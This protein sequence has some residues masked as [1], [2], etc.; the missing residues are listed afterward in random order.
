LLVVFGQRKPFV[1]FEHECATS[2]Q[3]FHLDELAVPVGVANEAS[4]VVVPDAEFD[5]LA[6]REQALEGEDVGSVLLEFVQMG[7]GLF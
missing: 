7:L 2:G 6:K 1:A 5:E 4:R 3:V